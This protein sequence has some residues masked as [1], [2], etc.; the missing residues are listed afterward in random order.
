MPERHFLFISDYIDRSEAKRLYE[1]VRILCLI[2]TVDANFETKVRAVEGTWAKRCNRYYF[3]A[4][5]RRTGPHIINIHLDES[6]NNLMKKIKSAY[7][8]VYDNFID[9][10]DWMF[11]ADDDTYAIL[12]N[13]RFLLS[14]YNSSDK[15]YLGYHFNRYVYNGYMSGGAGYVVSNGA[16]RKLVEEGID[17]DVCNP[18]PTKV[19]PEVSEDVNIGK[20]L[21][22]TGVTVLSSL[23]VH[24]RETFHPY[25]VH[26][27]LL[28][29][30]P[31]YMYSWSMNTPKTVCIIIKQYHSM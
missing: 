13:M 12:E 10:F 30:L 17:K 28:G 3:I 11:K 20:C 8:Y 26:Q 29:E 16:L 6:R 4:N 18:A 7:K 5:T 1:K 24:G 31:S 19:D 14:N 27:N 25:P 23:D 22:K 15:G 21:N 9:D 2:L